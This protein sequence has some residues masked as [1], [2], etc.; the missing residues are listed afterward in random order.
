M[1]NASAHDTPPAESRLRQGWLAVRR[2]VRAASFWSAVTLPFLYLPLF[3]V[4]PESGAEWLVVA[5]LIALHAV[6]LLV[7]HA[8]HQ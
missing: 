2:T 4:G 5:G 8:H 7:G 1:S 3:V 6:A